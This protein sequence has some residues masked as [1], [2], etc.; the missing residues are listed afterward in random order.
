MVYCHQFGSNQACRCTRTETMAEDVKEV[1][2]KVNPF[3]A[4][5]DK[6]NAER[7]GVG[8]R[9]FCGNT[10]GKGSQPI[11]WEAFD[12]SKP[13]TLPKTMKEFAEITGVKSEAD[14]LELVIDGFSANQYRTASDPIAEFV[15]PAWDADLKLKFRNVV[16][17]YS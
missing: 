17:N 6:V 9:L 5:V 14:I 10:R 1:A 16:R 11:K 7:T 2:E 13:E 12:D 8:L 4:E 3:Q 15:N